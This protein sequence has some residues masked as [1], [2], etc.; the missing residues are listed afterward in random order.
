MTTTFKCHDVDPRDLFN[1]YDR[2]RQEE[3]VT[4]ATEGGLLI[5]GL[6]HAF[7]GGV[8]AANINLRDGWVPWFYGQDLKKNALLNA[9]L[10]AYNQHWEMVFAPDDIW[11]A[12][13]HG[14]ARHINANAEEL[15]SKFVDWDGKK[16]IEIRRDNFVKGSPANDWLGVF[17]EFSDQIGEFIGKK[18]D[19]IV[20]D[21]TTTGPV[22]KA[23]SE[24]VLLDAMQSYFTYGMR[25][26]SGFSRVT[27]LGEV[28]DW[29]NI[30]ARVQHLAEF[31]LSW[32]TEHLEPVIDQFIAAAK[33]N[34]DQ[35]FW[36]RAVNRLGGSGRDDVTGWVLALFPYLKAGRS[37]YLNWDKYQHRGPDAS[38]FQQA[39]SKAPFT[40]HYHA[41]E[42][43]MEFMGGLMAPAIDISGQ[44]VR[45]A[46]GWAIRE[47]K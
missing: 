15:R 24:V 9:M 34:P 42:F 33:G 1:E 6:N 5:E 19:L 14:F 22:E 26:V 40:W 28:S 39:I 41:D 4:K 8:E 35:E 27:V 12:I 7:N 37:P 45:T 16:Y 43:K 46:T 13:A 29:E 25:T 23:A 11:L 3:R 18:R 31:G 44:R 38:E 21:F 2:E 17:A 10:F 30:K 32:W 36:K 47:Q 20:S